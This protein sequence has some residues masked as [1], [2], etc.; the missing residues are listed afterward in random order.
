MWFQAKC[1]PA[2]VEMFH[3][4]SAS[5]RACAM[6]VACLRCDQWLAALY[7]SFLPSNHL[8]MDCN[9]VVEWVRRT[10]VIIIWGMSDGGNGTG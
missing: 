4:Y 1:Q 9:D 7:P 2:A 5:H 3:T 6:L 10:M 8:A